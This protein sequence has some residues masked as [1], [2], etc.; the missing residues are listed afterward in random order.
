[1]LVVT[2]LAIVGTF[3]ATL[4]SDSRPVLG[5]D[6]QGGISIALF[7]VKG[8]DLGGLNAATTAIR[9]RVDGLGI[10]EPDV[11]R[12]GDTI[13]VNLPGVKDRA[14]AERLVGETA[15]LRFRPVLYQGTTPLQIP[16]SAQP[17]GTTTTTGKGGTTTTGTGGTTTS[18]PGQVTGTTNA[19]TTT[20]GKA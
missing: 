15:E 17:T 10:A 8:T 12:Q 18:N 14:K 4:L 1:M 7:P 11:Q 3:V 19:P 9:N 13:V 16:F 20:K 6:L 2:V 5:L